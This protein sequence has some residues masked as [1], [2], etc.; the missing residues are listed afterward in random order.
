MSEA[1]RTPPYRIETE[2]TVLRCYNPADAQLLQEAITLSMDHLRPWMPWIKFE[3]EGVAAKAERLRAFRGRFDLDQDYIYGIF[4]PDESDLIGGTGLHTRIGEGA[5]EIGYWISVNYVGQGYATEAG[6]ALTKVA[7][8][9]SAIERMEI[10]CDP[11]NMRS[12][13]VPSKLGYIHEATLRH[14]AVTAD[15]EPRDSMVWT[16]LA[17]EYAESPA[18]RTA[19]KAFDVLGAPIEPP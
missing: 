10:H 19:L 7:F 16:M 15:G 9:V 11:A 4:T 18:R 13:A 5:L 3:P 2:R 12:A 1:H 6:A 8:E 14:R 17:E